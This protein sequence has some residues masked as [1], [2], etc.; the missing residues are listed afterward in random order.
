LTLEVGQNAQTFS[1]VRC[2]IEPDQKSI[3]TSIEFQLVG[4]SMP[5]PAQLFIVRDRQASPPLTRWRLSS[6][7]PLP[8]AL[9][10]NYLEPL[11]SLGQRAKFRGDVSCT[12]AREGFSTELVGEF[13]EVDLSRLT[14]YLPHRLSG[15]ATVRL[16]HA[17]AEDGTFRS[18]QGSLVSP[19]GTVSRSFVTALAQHVPLAA[20]DIA[21]AANAPLTPYDRLAFQFALSG[22]TCSL[23][24]LDDT[25]GDAILTHRGAPL[26]TCD[27]LQKYSVAA[28][29]RALT[30]DSRLLV[31]A[32]D[33][34]KSLLGLFEFPQPSVR[35][36]GGA[37]QVSPRIR[38]SER[39]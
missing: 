28:F 11:A 4:I 3:R 22:D 17:V 16:H 39:P 29:L 15:F 37:G 8:C 7:T 20:P 21:L 19:G 24:G 35:G 6:T 38:L 36:T 5:A 14:E 9:F 13:D 10:T 12:L 25:S 31:P 27:R 34:T 30:P 23:A 32:T 18:I 33:A 2:T 26:L 1:T